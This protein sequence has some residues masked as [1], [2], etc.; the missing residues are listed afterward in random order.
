[1][2]YGL[3]SY[4]SEGLKRNRE[5]HELEEKLKQFNLTIPCSQRV[6]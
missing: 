6:L 4:G 5:R 3:V 1:M 2:D